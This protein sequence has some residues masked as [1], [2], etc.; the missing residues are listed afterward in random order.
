MNLDK[1]QGCLLGLAIGDALG[2][3]VE[4]REAG[5]FEPVTGYR[6]GGEFNLEAGQWT[7]DSSMALCLAESLLVCQDIDLLDQCQRYWNWYINGENSSTG[8]CFDIGT[9]TQEALENWWQTGRV[10]PLPTGLGNGCIMRLAPVPIFYH[11]TLSAAL[12]SGLSAFTTHGHTQSM[13]ATAFF[14]EL[15]SRALNGATKEDLLSIVPPAYTGEKKLT[16]SGHVVDTLKA[17]LWAFESS[18]SFE[19]T[20]LRAVNLGGDADTVGA[21]AGQLAGAFYG[22]SGIPEH[23]ITGLQDAERFLKVAKNLKVLGG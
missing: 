14:G 2:A 7:D 18:H 15:L 10:S 12:F 4:F 21:V 13:K 20:V 3:P 9:G 16:V 1:S 19:E 5:S 6:G 22:L 23:L 11:D 17:A 8:I